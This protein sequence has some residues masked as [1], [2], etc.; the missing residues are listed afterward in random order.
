MVL[1]RSCFAGA[2][3][4]STVA[5]V[6]CDNSPTLPDGP[7]TRTETFANFLARGGA[8]SRSFEVK[9]AGDVTMTLT[10][11]GVSDVEVGIAIGRNEGDIGAC[12]RDFTE[13]TSVAAA[14]TISRRFEPGKYC[15][16]VYDVGQLPISTSFV[17]T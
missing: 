14:K 17:A 7:L 5:A 1:L 15:A 10:A 16:T 3:L 4:L 12:S 2:L 13:V 6:G 11:L 9:D 8:T